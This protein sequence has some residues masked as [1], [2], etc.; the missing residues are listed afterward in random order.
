M[1]RT[2]AIRAGRAYVELFTKDGRLVKGLKRA[3]ARL[4][5]FGASV[6]MMGAK[7]TALGAAAAAATSGPCPHPP[8]PS[9]AAI[10]RS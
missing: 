4:K 1:E 7:L 9:A 3:S 5:A 6:T 8:G 10:P 2:N